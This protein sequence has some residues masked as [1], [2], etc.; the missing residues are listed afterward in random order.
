MNVCARYKVLRWPKLPCWLMCVFVHVKGGSVNQCRCSK[1]TTPQRCNSALPHMQKRSKTWLSLSWFKRA[2]PSG[3][4]HEH[5][6]LHYYELDLVKH[7]NYPV[8]DPFNSVRSMLW[9]KEV[10]PINW[11]QQKLLQNLSS[12]R[13]CVHLFK[14]CIHLQPSVMCLLIFGWVDQVNC[15][16]VCTIKFPQTHQDLEIVP[17]LVKNSHVHTGPLNSQMKKKTLLLGIKHLIRHWQLKC[18]AVKYKGGFVEAWD[19]WL[20]WIA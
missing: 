20:K 13:N 16:S 8:W 10:G 7:C 11:A 9:K 2:C 6:Q 17:P 14:S 18:I 15:I 5:I 4:L 12:L 1:T 19:D 3:F